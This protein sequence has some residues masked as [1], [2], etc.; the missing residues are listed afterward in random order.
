MSG[1]TPRR[2]LVEHLS[3]FRYAEPAQGSL[4]VLR[5]HP[6]TD[7]EQR[8]ASFGLEIDPAA[9]P[10]AFQDPFGN[11]C[12]LFNVHRSHEHTAVKSRAEVET[13]PAPDL[14]ERIE[15]D[16]WA[17]LAEAAPPLAYWEFLT[18]S[19]FARPSPALAAFAE[20]N[21]L[22]KGGDPL[23]SLLELG[24][25]LHGAF[26]Y[27]PGSTAV[28]SPIEHIL[29]TGS[30]VCQDYT[31]VMIAIA[32]SWGIPS[33]YVS[34]YLHREGAPGEQTPEGASHAWA[35]FLLPDLG[36]FGIDPTNDTIA[37][38][39][40]VRIAV[41]RDYADAAPTRGA[42]FGGGESRL[43]VVV[44]VTESGE[45][46][47]AVAPRAE[48]PFISDATPTPTVPQAGADQ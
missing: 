20:T 12:H 23:S 8:V 43:D 22:R 16:A 2:F 9:A 27:E 14:P 19:N 7:G 36:W 10:I 40:H 28:D 47:P 39:R 11:A 45:P 15:G 21:G 13:A 34:G 25:A 37:D 6:R 35:E 46:E 38:H 30:G 4:M 5:L 31:H 42:V 3:D 32:R 33:R 24:R 41:G 26:R 48:R 18:P 29:E 1:D 17:A 44:T